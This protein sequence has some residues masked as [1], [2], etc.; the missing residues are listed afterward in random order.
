[1][2]M[3]NYCTCIII[4]VTDLLGDDEDNINKHEDDTLKGKKEELKQIEAMLLNL[5]VLL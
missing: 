1:M 3:Y 4:G 2:Y 5:Q